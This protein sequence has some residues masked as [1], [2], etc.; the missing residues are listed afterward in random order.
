MPHTPEE[1]NVDDS[2]R[3]L[4][5]G[6]ELQ[7]DLLWDFYSELRTT[8]RHVETTRSNAVNYAL[9]VGAALITLITLDK[10]V[11]HADWPLCLVLVVV[12]LFTS[13]YS[14]LYLERYLRTKK[15]ARVVLD[16]IDARFFSDQE[17]AHRLTG[18]RETADAE[19]GEYAKLFKWVRSATITTHAFLLV[20][21]LIIFVLGCLLL[22]QALANPV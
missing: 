14:L 13:A 22:I 9:V 19:K 3:D 11:D 18:L 17:W 7:K 15:R 1:G 21:P 20:V 12:S 8:S 5:E 10:K 16:E 2:A 6:D 4:S